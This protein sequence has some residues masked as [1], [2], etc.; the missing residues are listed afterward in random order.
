MEQI[1]KQEKVQ[2]THIP[3]KG[4]AEGQAAL[5]GGHILFWVGDVNPS[6]TESGETRILMLL[7]DEHSNEY[8]QTPILRDLGYN[9]PYPMIMGIITAKAVPD[10]IVRKL[11]DIFS[12]AMKTPAF[13]NG[14]KDL[15]LAIIYRNSKDLDALVAQNYDNF[16]KL[17]KELGLTKE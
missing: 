2:I 12:K 11:D 4:T 8:P 5:L 7:R 6:L 13:I 9:M 16:S 1:A 15:R 3:F 10:G 17:F 14:M